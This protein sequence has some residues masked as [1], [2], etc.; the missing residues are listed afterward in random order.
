MHSLRHFCSIDDLDWGMWCD[1]INHKDAAMNGNMWYVARGKILANLFFEP[2]T[3]TRLSFESAMLRLGGQTIGFSDGSTSSIS[4]GESRT[5]TA[6]TVSEYADIIVVRDSIKFSPLRMSQ[7]SHV[8][9][10]NAGDGTNEHPTQTLADLFTIHERFCKDTNSISGLKIGLCG[11]L[12]NG[13]TTH[14]LTKAFCSLHP[15]NEFYF[16][17]P[18]ELQMPLPYSLGD[19]HRCDR[20]E[21][22]IGD[23]DVLYMTRPQTERMCP[24][25]KTPLEYYI[26]TPAMMEKAKRDMIVMHPLPRNGE[27]DP[28]IDTDERAWYFKQV[29]NGLYARMCLIDYLLN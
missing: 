6:L 26:L 24:E 5:D 11:D 1:L 3:R 4:K 15:N 10:I 17:A 14:S 28:R 19:Y 7:S 29:R 23:L 25:P 21:D 12:R 22:I 20:L 18:D 2:S 8:P 16:I 9:I 27:I 13:R